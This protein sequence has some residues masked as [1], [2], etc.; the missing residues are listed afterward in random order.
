MYPSMIIAFAGISLNYLKVRQKS[1]KTS[2]QN[3][4]GSVPLENIFM[5]DNQSSGKTGK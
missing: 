2:S 3:T 5:L 4:E 1:T